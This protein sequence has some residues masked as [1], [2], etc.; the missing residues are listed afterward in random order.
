VEK[1]LEQFDKNVILF[2]RKYSN[3]FA[4]FSLFVIYGWFGI[5]KVFELSPAGPLVEALQGA[6]FWSSIPPEQFLVWFG[7]FEV[8]LGVFALVPKLERIT[9]FLIGLHLITTVMPLFMLPDIAWDGFLVPSLIGQYIIKNLAL[10]SLGLIL[11]ARLK[12][13]TETHKILAQEDSS[14]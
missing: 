8:L 5:L 11:F 7:V 6:T 14:K 12:P 3:G 10:L 1:R 9:F 4:R 2:F 13:M